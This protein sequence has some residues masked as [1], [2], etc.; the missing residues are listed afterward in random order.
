[1]ENREELGKQPRDD[2]CLRE[3]G[4]LDDFLA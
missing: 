4:D 2:V 1:V 3:A